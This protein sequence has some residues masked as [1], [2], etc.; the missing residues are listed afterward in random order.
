MKSLAA[1]A[2]PAVPCSGCSMCLQILVALL[3]LL[4]GATS[5]SAQPFVYVVGVAPNGSPQFG[6]IDLANG[7]FH[8]VAYTQLDNTPVSLANLVWRN[9]SLLTLA[10]SGSIAGD[11]V[12]INPATGH[13]TVIGA[14]GLGYNAF[15][16]G[17]VNG[18]LYLTDFNTGGSSQNIYS[19]DPDTGAATLIGAT[20]VPA[21]P[22]VPFTT[23]S[24]GTFNLCDESFYGVGGKL[25]A[26]FDSFNVL[27]PTLEV[28]KYPADATVSPALYQIDPSSGATTLVAPTNLFVGTTIEIHGTLYG[29]KSV[30][31]GFPGGF[32]ASF[33]ELEKIN[34]TTGAV[35][36]LRVVDVRAGVIFGAADTL[37]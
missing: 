9:G 7:R 10:T 12:K 27:T 23:N 6:T 33:S 22:N 3:A 28:D 30:I 36:F 13:I 1:K 20:G 16:L 37:P 18:K 4:L 24:D 15:S 14:T 21:D 8:R 11:L 26:T 29:F 31:T 5:A 25:Y 34:L 2:I 32:P 17:K 19:V 35:T